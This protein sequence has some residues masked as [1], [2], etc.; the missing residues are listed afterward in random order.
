MSPRQ[1]SPSTLAADQLA[2]RQRLLVLGG[3]TLQRLR[4]RLARVGDHHVD[5]T[6]DRLADPAHGVGSG[7][8]GHAPP[9]GQQIGDQDDRP[10]HR[11][12]ASATPPT[13]RIGIRLVKKLPGPMTT[14]SNSAMASPAAGCSGTSGSSHNPRDSPAR[15]WPG[16]DFHLAARDRAVGVLGAERRRLD[17]DRPDP[18]GA[19]EQRAQAVDRGEKVAA[20]ALHHRQQQVAAG[21]PAQPFVLERRQP[22]QQ[23]APRFALVARERQRAAQHVAWRQH[24]QLVAQLP[25]AAAACRTSSPRR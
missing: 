8:G 18:P 4:R 7:E 13:S 2:E 16:V 22:R 15:A 12:S 21:V 17:A 24:A 25:R 23:H 3:V 10:V 9:F 14:A 6:A 19:A 11:C 20:V 1:K 5:R